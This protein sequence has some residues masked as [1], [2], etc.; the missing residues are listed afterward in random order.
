MIYRM[1]LQQWPGSDTAQNV[2][3]LEKLQPAEVLQR[4]LELRL[5]RGNAALARGP[6]ALQ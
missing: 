5:L 3:A 1:P 2:P 6:H 4:R